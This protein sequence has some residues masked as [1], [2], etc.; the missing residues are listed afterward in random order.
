MLI[1]YTASSFRQAISLSNT[2]KMFLKQLCFQGEC[3]ISGN[4]LEVEEKIC[5]LTDNKDVPSIKFGLSPARYD[6]TIFCTGTV[7]YY[8]ENGT[9]LFSAHDRITLLQLLLK[10]PITSCVKTDLC[11]L[12]ATANIMTGVE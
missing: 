4:Y 11:L 5:G 2:T 8:G 1:E 9:N 3:V 12:T 10:K 6:E 7:K